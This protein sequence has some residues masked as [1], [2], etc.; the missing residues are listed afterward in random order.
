MMRETTLWAGH[1]ARH[2]ALEL[3]L[4]R[5][6]AILGSYANWGNTLIDIK[7][8]QNAFC[9]SLTFFIVFQPLV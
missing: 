5:V 8:R 7:N 3:V 2:F 9:L 1:S 4:F 6:K